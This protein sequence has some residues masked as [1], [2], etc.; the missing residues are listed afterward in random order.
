VPPASAADLDSEFPQCPFVS[1]VVQGFASG[2]AFLLCVPLCPLWLKVC[3]SDFPMTRDVQII[4]SVYDPLPASLSHDPTRHRRFVANKSSTPIQPSDDRSVEGFK[5]LISA[6]LLAAIEPPFSPLTA[7]LGRGSQ[8]T[9]RHASLDFN[10]PNYPITNFFSPHPDI[11]DSL[12]KTNIKPQF[13]KAVIRQS[14]ALNHL[15]LGL[16]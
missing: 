1:F 11:L 15:V 2:F 10:L 7:M 9:W 13:D 14:K 8:T 16:F 3:S 5:S 6:L 12:L 4:R